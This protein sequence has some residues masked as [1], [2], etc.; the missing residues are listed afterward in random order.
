MTP[1]GHKKRQ[2]CI[3]NMLQKCDEKTAA[4]AGAKVAKN[5]KYAREASKNVGDASEGGGPGA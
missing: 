1:K 5:G 3:K 4:R 2:T